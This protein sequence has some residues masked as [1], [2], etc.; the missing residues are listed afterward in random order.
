MDMVSWWLLMTWGMEDKKSEG[1][2]HGAGR[3][4]WGDTERV[5]GAE[6]KTEKADQQ[7]MRCMRT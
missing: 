6:V 5:T 2:M 7:M 4:V 3:K 1:C